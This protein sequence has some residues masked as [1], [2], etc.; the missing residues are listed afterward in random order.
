MINLEKELFEM[1]VRMNRLF[2]EAMVIQPKERSEPF[3]GNSNRQENED[4][5]DDADNG[6]NSNGTDRY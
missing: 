6:G 2:A 5:T 3:C 4:N 1:G